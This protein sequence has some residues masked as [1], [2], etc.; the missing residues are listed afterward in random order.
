MHII[1]KM[2]SH[3][4]SDLSQ[5]VHLQKEKRKKREK[6]LGNTHETANWRLLVRELSKKDSVLPRPHLPTVW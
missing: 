1:S 4:I 5:F 3:P 2:Y 6:D